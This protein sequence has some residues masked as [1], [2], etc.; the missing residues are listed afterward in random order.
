M[1][2][3]LFINYMKFMKNLEAKQNTKSG[4]GG[5]ELIF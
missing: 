3:I 5:G 4:G 1:D 2:Q